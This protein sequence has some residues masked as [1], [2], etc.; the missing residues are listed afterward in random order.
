[1]RDKEN[2]KKKIIIHVGY[3]KCG[4]T[5]IQETMIENHALLLKSG[6]LFPKAVQNNPSWWLRFFWESNLPLRFPK[7]RVIPKKTQF[8]MELKQEIRETNAKTIILSDEGLI[9]LDKEDVKSFYEYMI[10]EFSGYDFEVVAIVRNPISFLTSRSQQFMSDRCFTKDSIDRFLSGNECSDGELRSDNV[11]MNPKWLFSRNLSNYQEVFSGISLIKFEDAVKD[12]VG[13]THYFLKSI[14]FDLDLKDIRFNESRSD[15]AIE[16]ISY[17]GS[18]VPF[19]INGKVNPLRNYA[20]LSPLYS[21]SGGKFKLERSQVRDLAKGLK[22]EINWLKNK[23]N[24]NYSENDELFLDKN[25]ADQ[26][27]WDELFH[28]EIIEIFPKI[29]P[30]L[31][32]FVYQFMLDKMAKESCPESQECL[33]KVIIELEEKFPMSIKYG[34]FYRFIFYVKKMLR[35]FKFLILKVLRFLKR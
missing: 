19:S 18:K 2:I 12:K 8:L 9:S 21:L 5:T 31:R 35:P 23:F 7:K 15:K 3:S 6:C 13:F 17:I 4:S 29:V 11:A 1:M 14:G 16:I 27:V 30:H 32:K 26:I 20:D 10:S 34:P 22:P 24:I 25:S 33:N 28:K